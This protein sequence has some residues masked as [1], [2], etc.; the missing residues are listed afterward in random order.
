MGRRVHEG[1]RLDVA[2][3]ERRHLQDDRGQVGAEDLR[4]GE[5]GPGVVVVLAVEA[6]ADSGRHP[7][8]PPGPLVGGRLADRLDGQALDLGAPAEARDAGRAGVD[9]VAHAG[10]RDRGLGHVGGQHDAPAGVGPEGPGLLGRRQACVEGQDLG[11]GQGGLAEG[12]GGV[13]DLPLA[14]QEHEDVAGA[15]AP[16]LVDRPAD[17]VD[18]VG[19]ALGPERAVADLDRVGPAR[20]LDDRRAEVL[21]EPLGVDGGRRDDD[22]EVGPA[23]EQVREVAEKEVDV[24]AALVGLVDDEGVVAAQHP[25]P[26]HLGQQDAVGH[27]LD[28]RA[29]ADLVREPHGV[30]HQVAHRGA[31][32]VGHPGGHRA[33]GEAPGLGVAD[34]A[35]H[36]PA[37]LQAQLG[38]LGA[39]A[40]PGLAR[41]HHELVVADG[42][43]QVVAARR[44]GQG[45]GVGDRGDRIA[46][47]GDPGL[48]LGHLGGHRRQGL[49]V[50]GGA[51]AV[52]PAAE[53]VLVT[54]GQRAEAG[55][56]V[57]GGGRHGWQPAILG[58]PPFGTLVLESPT[59]AAK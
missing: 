25:V 42:R 14:R 9:D 5:R 11:A 30:A 8:A 15:L 10:H 21:G 29:L 23:G 26:L 31:Q 6:D 27:Q 41:H 45:L 55:A 48:G 20:H 17:A 36:A 28:Q 7:P 19:A 44:D 32:L 38:E 52:E 47:P 59:R 51:G 1:E 53:A 16:Q 40:R 34:E 22:L 54:Q 56:E 57:G 3:P 33:G 24:E 18:L 49:A 13:A 58:I 50:A 37:Q 12:G 4:L 2:Q 39:L 35:A 43:G 46:T